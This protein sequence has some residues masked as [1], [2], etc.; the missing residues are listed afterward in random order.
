MNKVKLFL[1]LPFL[2][3]VSCNDDREESLFVADI[4]KQDVPKQE[5]TVINFK[6]LYSKHHTISPSEAR[7]IATVF[8]N[9]S[10]KNVSNL[11]SKK[12]SN[13]DV[14][15]IKRQLGLKSSNS[16]PDTLAYIIN[17]DNDN[18][19]IIVA[20]D[21]RIYNPVLA[22]TEKGHYDEDYINE[23]IPALSGAINDAFN[24]VAYE[25][26]NFEV[27]KDSLRS[28]ADSILKS[29]KYQK[30]D[31][32][33][34]SY[35]TGTRFVYIGE[36]ESP[37]WLQTTWGQDGP[38]NDSVP[39]CPGSTTYRCVAGCMATAVA[40]VMAYWKYPSSIYGHTFN[41]TGMT[42]NPNANIISTNDKKDVAYL[43]KLIGL[44]TQMNYGCSES[45]T[46]WP[47]TKPWLQY[48]L[49]YNIVDWDY[50]WTDVYNFLVLH[51][52]V[53]MIATDPVEDAAHAWVLDGYQ[54]V[55]YNFES[56]I[57]DT[58]NGTYYITS[59]TPVM[60]NYIHNNWGWDGVCNGYF[61]ADTFNP[62]TPRDGVYDTQ[63]TSMYY[64]FTTTKKIHIIS[65]NNL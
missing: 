40:Q 3:F 15:V 58:D 35:V 9:K 56:Y 14:K 39:F 26:D 8:A 54:S 27:Q 24:Y 65:P 21:D 10:S 29:G 49:G 33:L 57:L 13:E 22:I 51:A 31:K 28:I 6:A 46:T 62:M 18:G 59:S 16:R 44:N 47:N 64:N 19:F 63:G 20:A 11:K 55:F 5:Q 37:N 32:S 61:L 38:Y 17:F 25:I 23:N 12:S 41:W 60:F 2:L 53:I 50:S 43:F 1:T 34:K 48:V 30:I 52:P 45:G 4:S 42:S 36:Y 7:Q